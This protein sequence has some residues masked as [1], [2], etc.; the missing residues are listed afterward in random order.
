MAG[1]SFVGREDALARLREAFARTSAV[2][3][4]WCFVV[5]GEAGIGKTALL[6][7]FVAELP[8][9]A[10]VLVTA[11]E[12]EAHVDH[13]VVDALLRR[14]RVASPGVMPRAGAA[15]DLATVG[16]RLLEQLTDVPN[17]ERPAVVVIDDAHWAD[18]AS[19][20]ALLFAL[21]RIE[22]RRPLVVLGVRA[23]MLDRLPPGFSAPDAVERL[24]LGGLT[25]AEVGALAAAS[26]TALTL[27]AARALRE[28]AGGNPLYVGALL[29]EVPVAAW[30]G[31]EPLPPAP[32]L[33]ARLVRRRLDGAAPATYALVEAAA[34]LGARAEPRSAAALAGL[35]D[36]LDALEE[37][38]RLGLLIAD[39]GGATVSFDHPLTRAAVYHG[40]GA[41]RRARL[42]ARAA[43]VADQPGTALRHRAAAAAA[44][45]TDP[46][47]ADELEAFA[48]GE[49]G[50]GAWD[51][52]ADL[53][54]AA[55]RLSREGERDR[56]EL[57]V[58]DALLGAGRVDA[59]RA[60]LE[61]C[62][63]TSE[64]ALRL[65]VLAHVALQEGRG[66]EAERLLARAWESGEG[67]R[68]VR[69][70]VAER[71][72][73][74]ALARLRPDDAIAWTRRSA[75]LGDRDGVDPLL[76]R[77]PE[78]LACA[79]DGR[80]ADGR[81]LAERIVRDGGEQAASNLGYRWIRGSLRL[82]DDDLPGALEELRMVLTTA[83]G[84]GAERVTVVALA[85]LARAELASGRWDDAA[86]HAERALALAE[87]GGHEQA[88]FDAR[89][90]VVAVA[91][92]RGELELAARQIAQ[93]GRR[94]SLEGHAVRVASAQA[95]LAAADGRPRDV[96]ATVE[97]LRA[98]G[99]L[100][101]AARM[102]ELRLPALAA[103]AFV[104]LGRHEEAESILAPH[105]AR[106]AEL[107]QRSCA[108]ALARARARL[109]TAR[110]R[111]DDAERAV[112]KAL[113]GAAKLEQ[114]YEL[115][116]A[117][118]SYG[119]LLRRRGERRRALAVLAQARATFVTLGARPALERCERELEGGGAGVAPAAG[120]RAALTGRERAVAQLAARG[121]T[122]R[123]I[124]AEL[125]VSVKTVEVHLTRIF[126]KLAISSRQQ[127][128][129]RLRDA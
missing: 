86:V 40:M 18:P 114:P 80:T 24:R 128:A 113:D 26:G 23:G 12:A 77:W 66:E 11:E 14:L 98:D 107:G 7:R 123:E 112:Q 16:M 126:A 64:S 109:E 45:G 68:L 29:E 120:G 63:T 54:A 106:A 34:V 71:R 65:C 41:A 105:E 70:R 28:H 88:I 115:A 6:R 44:L 59:A 85:A 78:P 15:P 33:F 57:E 108:V 53:F 17:G 55:A 111:H 22:E 21:R 101:Q 35:A 13:A 51:S 27:D 50:R 10:T 56:R 36:P 121:L 25:A 3:R 104:R 89:H 74:V 87:A 30:A 4:P 110:G 42:H 124:A 96:V 116:L 38:E 127:V 2:A 90:A 97:R 52:A 48:G 83:A 82:L 37:G 125:M 84:L 79:V 94:T 129:A 91:V 32:E 31:G 117:R 75:E 95:G 9:A 60:R 76:R 99:L 118:L 93:L 62:D 73:A 102:P 103:E 47:L 8:T 61:Q 100:E 119:E 72:A 46:A 69:R 39:P 49:I 20:R 122:N 81:A 92:A 58:A 1:A 67:T 19:L 5:E 43:D